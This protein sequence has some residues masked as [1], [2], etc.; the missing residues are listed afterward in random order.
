MRVAVVTEYYPRAGDPVLGMW[1]H[2]QALAAVDA[3]A[4][5]RVIVLYRPIPPMRTPRRELFGA[6]RDALRQPRHTELDGIP[7]HYVRFVSPQ[8]DRSYGSWGRWATPSLAAALRRLRRDFPFD[9]VHAH[10]AVPAGD[11]VRRSRITT[12]FVVSVHGSDVFYTAPIAPGGEEPVRAT[13]AAARLVLANSS[14]TERMA[15]ALGAQRTR[16]VHLGADLPE[17]MAAPH[18]RSDGAA[19]PLV[20]VTVGHLVA[21]KRHGDVLRAM[22]ALREECPA[23]RYVIVGDGPER[24]ALEQLAATLGVAD[25]VTFTGQ[26]EHEHALEVLRTQADAFVMPSTD[27]AL[28][29][30]YLE[31]MGAG[32]PAVGCVGEPGPQDIAEAGAGLSLVAPGDIEDLANAIGALARDPAYRHGAG[33]EAR[34]TVAEH[35]TWDAC[36]AATV[37]AYEEALRA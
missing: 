1:A 22:W 8:R 21:R 9:L 13:F 31:A 36:G 27:E 7:V 23:L 32:V 33:I 17:H 37:A 26:L 10:N 28:G 15:S 11:A 24:P 16:V 12:P 2:R 29:V 20:L 34:A 5:V 18:P 14:G 25:R 35:F 3:G 19:A 6:T 30:A 4:D